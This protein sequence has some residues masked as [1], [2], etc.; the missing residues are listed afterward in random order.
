MIRIILILD[1]YRNE[2]ICLWD[3][4]HQKKKEHIIL[5]DAILIYQKNI[6]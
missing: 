4:L 3:N 5:C 6:R 2:A 1:K